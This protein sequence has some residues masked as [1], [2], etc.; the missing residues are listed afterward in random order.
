M[1]TRSFAFLVSLCLT[2]PALTAC[3][4]GGGGGA[5]ALPTVS[6][7]LSASAPSGGVPAAAVPVAISVDIPASSPQSGARRP[8]YVSAGTKSIVVSYG[9]NRQTAD[10]TTTCSANFTVV[11]GMVTFVISLYDASGGSG[12][13]LSSGQ[14]TASIQTGQA[15]VVK[16]S[17][18]GIV[19]KVAITLGSASITAGTPATI[20]VN[21]VAQDAAGFTIIG[22]N[23]Y[24][25]AISL[26]SDDA[27]GA[28]S[29]STTS[30]D[31][32][33]TTVSLTYK[34]SGVP[35]PVHIT[36]STAGVAAQSATLVVTAPAAPATSAPITTPAPVSGAA[37]DHVRNFAYYGINGMDADIPAAYMAAHVDI[38]ED[39]G[40]SAQHA[41]AFK[42]AGGKIALAYTD[43]SYVPYCPPPFTAPAGICSGPIGNLV[44]GD[45]S[46][47]LH[48]AS[49]A[50]INRFVDSH[51][52]Y[53]EA[54]NLGAAS[55]QGAYRRQVQNILASSPL[56]DGFEAD[57]SGSPL[58]SHFGG[59]NAVGV[60]WANDAAY[61]AAESAILG[62]PGKPVLLNGGDPSTLGASYGGAFVDLS[63]VMG[64]MFEGC[65]N[66]EGGYL[67]T[68]ANGHQFQREVNGL[69]D[70]QSHRK[71]AL[72]LPTGSATDPARR[73]YAYAAFMLAYDPQYSVYGMAKN[74]SDGEAVFP[75][76]QLVPQS[77]RT[78]ATD[79]AQLRN[80]AVYVREFA[81]CSIAGQPIG[82]CATVVN[83][84][85]SASAAVPSLPSGYAHSV[86]LDAAS[87]YHGGKANVIAGAPSTLA[88]QS[89]AI[90]VR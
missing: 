49:G 41:D 72:C 23:A 53:Q 82:A 32:P 21:V 20:P 54:L 25:A 26:S 1:E 50:R 14:T 28:T 84:S 51:F 52:Q 9:Q 12:H 22:P 3:G 4:G 60:E 58:S 71:L 17:F 18:L 86:A 64:Q 34:G 36:A 63:S 76:T 75:E 6:G 24:A 77:P 65:F 66:N 7:G 55:A 31:A 89:A 80:G 11:P 70:V 87:L 8:L 61:Q 38:V 90:L 10:C 35:A 37:P 78:T 33:A 45:E 59:F 85:P 30:V 13:L 46:A 67:Y 40:F 73:L 68:D 69:L 27:S 74:Q 57:D 39:D 88:A 29:L 5:A 48:D 42:R 43:P 44:A 47:W 81:A 83:S 16:V 2:A 19:A 79:V 62:V 15:N 56:L